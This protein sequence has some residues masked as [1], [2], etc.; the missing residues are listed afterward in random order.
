MLKPSRLPKHTNQRLGEIVASSC[1]TLSPS[2]R[3]TTHVLWP[4]QGEEKLPF[5]QSRWCW[6]IDQRSVALIFPVFL[7]FHC[8]AVKCNSLNGSRSFLMFNILQDVGWRK[9]IL[10]QELPSATTA[11]H[12]WPMRSSHWRVKAL[13]QGHLNDIYRSWGLSVHVPALLWAEAS[14]PPDE[15]KWWGPGPGVLYYFQCPRWLPRCL[16]NEHFT[17][18][19]DRLTGSPAQANETAWGNDEILKRLVWHH[20]SHHQCDWQH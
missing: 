8:N 4:L 3:H 15:R 18:I 20:P 19:T 6:Q 13:A 12:C 17:V 9:A 11:Y 7:L 16:P 2:G 14:W 5:C 1:F 10:T